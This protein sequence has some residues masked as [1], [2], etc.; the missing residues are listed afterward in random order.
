MIGVP[1]LTRLFCYMSNTATLGAYQG[2]GTGTFYVW[3]A[4]AV[5]ANWAG[6]RTTTISAVVNTGNIRNRVVTKQNLIRYSEQLASW[7]G[8]K[9]GVVITADQ[10]T[11]PDG[12]LTADQVDFAAVTS[13]LYAIPLGFIAQIGETYTWS[14][15]VKSDSKAT[16]GL[17]LSN[18]DGTA[19]ASKSVALTSDWQRVET[20]FTM[21]KLGVLNSTPYGGLDNRVGTGGDGIAGTIYAWGGQIAETN[22]A[23][24][25]AQTV[26]SAV[27]AGAIR[28]KAVSRQTI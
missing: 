27:N 22:W 5:Q 12:T 13:Y 11:A 26:A 28:N 3:E 4:Q 21:T 1:Q 9:T 17:N 2:D 23:G 7:G 15:W 18:G 10:V 24:P 19:G 6:P 20:S 8:P 25:Y 14:I 16:I